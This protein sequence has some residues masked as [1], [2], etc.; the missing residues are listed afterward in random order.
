MRMSST[1]C[2]DCDAPSSSHYAIWLDALSNYL[3]P[4]H[5]IP[6][7]ATLDRWAVYVLNRLL[8]T[9][10][11]VRWV[12]LPVG[13]ALS[14]LAPRTRLF[15]DAARVRGYD[16]RIL[17]TRSGRLTNH[18]ALRN[19][20]GVWQLEGLPIPSCGMRGYAPGSIDDKWRAQQILQ[21][22]GVPVPSG[23][24][25]WFWQLRAARA[26]QRTTTT[27]LVVKPRSGSVARHIT[28]GVTTPDHLTRAFRHARAYDPCVIVQQ[29]YGG[30]PHRLTV[31]GEST[32]WCTRHTPPVITGTGHDTIDALIR[33]HTDAAR[34][35]SAYQMGTVHEVP[36]TT[37]LTEHLAAQGYT[38]DDILPR[39]IT[40]SLSSDPFLRNGGIVTEV[41]LDLHPDTALVARTIAR[42]FN[43]QL[44]GIDM[45]LEDVSRSWR[46]QTCAVLEVNSLPCVE[47]HALPRY[48][49]PQPVGTF[50]VDLFEQTRS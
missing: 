45:M 49:T 21:R 25:F 4:V 6:L 33:I 44:I 2:T 11:L 16:V 18:V 50:L 32:V 13:A 10:G 47:L 46:T 41:T 17:A 36:R 35:S 22:N 28:L 7:P 14:T 26:Y 31:I 34:E 12:P 39:G 24:R 29:Q 19:A 27:P 9:L 1:H 3:V 30:S 40:L 8:T 5:R 20:D 43:T 42:A 37:T 38:L 15:A 48:G 23:R